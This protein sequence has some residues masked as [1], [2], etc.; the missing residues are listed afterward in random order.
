MRA[1]DRQHRPRRLLRV[2]LGLTAQHR[3][4]RE[5]RRHPRRERQ[6]CCFF[7]AHACR[8]AW[9]TATPPH[10][11]H[12]KQTRHRRCQ[13]CAHRPRTV[14][15]ARTDR[16]AIRFGRCPRN[17][18][19]VTHNP[20]DHGGN[21]QSNRPDAIS[22]SPSMQAAATHCRRMRAMPAVLVR[23]YCANTNATGNPALNP[24]L[25][26]RLHDCLRPPPAP[27]GT[28]AAPDMPHDRQRRLAH[29]GFRVVVSALQNPGLRVPASHCGATSPMHCQ[30]MDAQCLH[31]FITAT[32]RRFGKD[33]KPCYAEANKQTNGIAPVKGMQCPHEERRRKCSVLKSITTT[34]G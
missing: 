25:L 14:M 21:V 19:T 9:L 17:A 18:R 11:N 12:C 13:Q 3:K 16:L 31:G 10:P 22:Q 28:F 24:A 5:R 34:A 4:Q 27:F 8:A 6:S 26:A 23:G 30:N 29:A 32:R 7:F 1:S 33:H 20:H 15:N 2:P